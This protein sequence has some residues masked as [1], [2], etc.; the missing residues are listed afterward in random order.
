MNNNSNLNGI[1]KRKRCTIKDIAE[2]A[3]VTSS[4]VSLVINNKK[5]ISEKTR[6]RVISIIE[7]LNYIPS[8]IA[9]GLVQKKTFVFGLIIPSISD[10]FFADLAKGVEDAGFRHGFSLI[11]CNSD[12]DPEKEKLYISLMIEQHA[13]GLIIVPCTTNYSFVELAFKANIPVIFADSRV[14]INKAGYVTSDNF[15][16]AYDLTNYLLK[17]GHRRIGCIV[18]IPHVDTIQER[19]KGHKQALV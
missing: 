3:G 6:L 11:V 2:I 16:G 19:V 1:V 5:G 15:K 4:T 7:K 17:L 13:A 12:Y 14:D 10:P 18:T 9:R 8:A